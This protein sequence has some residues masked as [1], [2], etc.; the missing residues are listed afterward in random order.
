M[1]ADFPVTIYHN[2][3]CGSSRNALTPDLPHEKKP[4][5][6]MILKRRKY[7]IAVI[8]NISNNRCIESVQQIR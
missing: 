6:K 5:M 7:S 4:N 3:N 2:P 1:T 8:Y